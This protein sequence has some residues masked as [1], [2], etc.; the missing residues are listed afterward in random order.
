MTFDG[1]IALTQ[2][3][4]GGEITLD[5]GQPVM[6]EG[7]ATAVYL[8]LFAGPYW[9]NTCVPANEALSST[10]DD[11]M[12]KPLTNQ[13]RLDIIEATKTALQ[14]L[15]DENISSEIT[16]EAE[17]FASTGLYLD[18]SIAEG[19][20]IRYTLNWRAEEAKI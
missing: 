15:V 18:I 17:I 10:F 1:D 19:G 6:D 8:S 14:W 5:H 4:D 7:L 9:G 12:R 2:T 20:N 11:L 3:T 16:V 13:T